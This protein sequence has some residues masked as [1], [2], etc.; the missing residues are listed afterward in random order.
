MCVC[1]Y[2]YA[3]VHVEA[4]EQLIVFVLLLCARALSRCVA[5]HF[6]ELKS[7]FVNLRILSPR[8]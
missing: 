5:A 8:L 2:I 3:F 7:Q 6:L 1:I 4:K